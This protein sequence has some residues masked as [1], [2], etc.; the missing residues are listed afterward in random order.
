MAVTNVYATKPF[1]I[2]RCGDR[3]GGILME[4]VGAGLLTD[5]IVGGAS[6]DTITEVKAAITALAPAY[7]KPFV[8]KIH[9]ALDKAIAIGLISETHG[10]T[11]ASGT[12]DSLVAAVTNSTSTTRRNTWF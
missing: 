11:E 9:D 8:S 1:H 7:K 5:A 2:Q 3:I 6:Y 10:A 4:A 12:A